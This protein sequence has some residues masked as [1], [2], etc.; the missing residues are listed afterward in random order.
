MTSTTKPDEA[1]RPA[2]TED[3]LLQEIELRAYFKYCDRGHVPCHEVEDWLAAEQ[4]VRAAQNGR[5]GSSI[6]ATSD[7]H[8]SK[9]SQAKPSRIQPRPVRAH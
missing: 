5:D 2:P 4:E 8:R 7:R 9:R 1:D 6:A 3:A